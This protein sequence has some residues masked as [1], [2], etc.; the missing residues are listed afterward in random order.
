MFAHNFG[1]PRTRTQNGNFQAEIIKILIF[2]RARLVHLRFF[3][4]RLL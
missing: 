3:N 4:T 1:L 2:K